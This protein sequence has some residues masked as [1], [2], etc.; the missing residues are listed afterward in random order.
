MSTEEKPVKQHSIVPS[1][2]V[3]SDLLQ[4]HLR[5]VT[6]GQVDAGK[7]TLV[8]LLVNGTLDNGRGSG[9]TSVFVHPH[10]IESGSKLKYDKYIDKQNQDKN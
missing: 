2:E 3:C 9:R 7:S 8:G 1:V 10:E 5:V 6:L 4:S